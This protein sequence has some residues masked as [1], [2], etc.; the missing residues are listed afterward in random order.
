MKKSGILA[1]LIVCMLAMTGCG[2]SFDRI[3]LEELPD[4][5]SLEQ[6]KKDGCVVEEDG[7]VT[8]GKEIFER[9]FSNTEKGKKD[10]VRL[11]SFYT[12]GDPSHY[13]P[14][15]YESIQNDYPLLYVQDLSF[16]GKEYTIRWYEDGEEIVRNYSYLLRYEGQAESS[17]ALYKSFVRYVLTNDDTVTWQELVQGLISSR[18]GDYIDHLSVCT[19][20]IY[21]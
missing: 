13:D 2:G 20:L 6:A 12:L 1:L 5:Y 7:D 9:F 18:Y 21:E 15:Y 3:S 4:T 17:N 19:D 11:V 16:D 14:D 8:A 10:S